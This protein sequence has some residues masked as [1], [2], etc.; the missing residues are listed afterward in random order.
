VLLLCLCV[1]L[2]GLRV[3]YLEGRCLLRLLHDFYHTATA[4]A[5]QSTAVAAAPAAAE[6]ERLAAAAAAPAA[7][8][9][10]V[11]EGVAAA[12]Q[13]AAMLASFLQS[14]MDAAGSSG[15]AQQQQQQQQQA[16]AAPC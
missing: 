1:L 16:S 12:E 15:S 7:A 9:L 8:N 13:V 3:V 6:A 11:V 14:F 10:S 5:Q 4:D 2:Q